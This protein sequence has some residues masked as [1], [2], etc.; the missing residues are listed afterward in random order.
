MTVRR[1]RFAIA[2][3]VLS[4]TAAAR[5]Q[6]L[7]AQDDLGQLVR[8]AAPAT[9]IVSLAP[10]VTEL[11]FA[12]GAG[13]QVVGTV[14]FSDYPPEAA[15]IPRVG[16]YAALD[17]ERILALRPTLVVGWQSGNGPVLERLRALGLTVYVTEPR[18]FEDVLRAIDDLGV[19]AGSAET[20]REE[21]TGLRTRLAALQRRYAQAPA[22]SVFYQVWHQPLMTVG[23]SHLVTRIIE[24][25]GG[26]N[27][28]ADVDALAPAVNVEA[29]LAA[30]PEAIVA[31]G[32]D[33]ARPEWLDDWRRWP[34]LPAVRD[35]HLFF[36]PPDLLQRPTPR[37]LD[38][39]ERLCVAVARVREA[40]GQ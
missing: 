39:A 19:L 11:L 5:A 17:I 27:V 25:C 34:Q 6:G 21:T 4:L 20:A 18:R 12:A 15:R 33:E 14:E 24:T 8:L 9:R 13:E 31:S 37:L 3:C 35:G 7:V 38:G 30:V 10:H 1:L 26:R 36:I 32:M 22:V 2:L 29:V 16:S 23:G 28:F 40:R